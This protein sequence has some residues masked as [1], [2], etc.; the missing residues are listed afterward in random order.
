VFSFFTTEYSREF[1]VL[2][3]ETKPDGTVSELIIMRNDIFVFHQMMVDG[4]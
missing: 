1:S 4:D 2:P 3:P